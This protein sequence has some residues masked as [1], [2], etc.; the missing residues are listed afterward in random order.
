M[1]VESCEKIAYAFEIS[2]EQSSKL[3]EQEKKK[4][5]FNYKLII[6]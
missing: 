6:M 4:K 2:T 3:G 1:A 5:N